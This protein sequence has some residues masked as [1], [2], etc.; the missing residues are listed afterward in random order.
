MRHKQMYRRM[1][2]DMINV[3]EFH[4]RLYL[5][6][7]DVPIVPLDALKEDVTKLLPQLRDTYVEYKESLEHKYYGTHTA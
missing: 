1:S 2:V 3:L 6:Y 4:S 7:G 5:V